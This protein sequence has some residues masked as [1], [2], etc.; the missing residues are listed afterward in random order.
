VTVRADW[1]TPALAAEP[2]DPFEVPE[3]IERVGTPIDLRDDAYELAAA[4]SRT[5]HDERQ[6]YDDGVTC[7]IKDVAHASCHVCPLFRNDGTPMARLCAI[8]REQERLCTQ[9]AVT[10]HGG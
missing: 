3:R 2:G 6:L 1:H 7:K 10:R 9:I 4:L 5:L 8:G